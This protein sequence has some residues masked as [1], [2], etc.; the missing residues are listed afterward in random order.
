MGGLIPQEGADW[1]AVGGLLG[2]PFVGS[3]LGTLILRLPEKTPLLWG[4][5][6][7]DHCST[8]LGVFDLVPL[9]SWLA[10]RGRCRHCGARLGS[11][12]PAVE[13]AALA[14][15]VSAIVFMADAEPWLLA[16]GLCLGWTLLALAWIDARTFLLPDALTLPLIVAGLLV[17]QAVDPAALADHAIAAVAGYGAF[18]LVGTAYRRSRGREGLGMGDAKLL[19]AAGAFLSWT[20]LPILVVIGSATALAFGLARWTL[21]RRPAMTE[22][23]PFGPFLALG[24]WIVWLLG[25]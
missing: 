18:W 9:L 6:R 4:R 14:V 12:Y 2:A 7:C 21:L 1:V 17:T 3:F 15:A 24:F 22:A 16:I 25:A 19:A 13:G 23:I 20:A 10:S 5:S 11:F 8:P